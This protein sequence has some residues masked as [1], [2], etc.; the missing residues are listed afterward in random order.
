MPD[1]VTVRN[2]V[3]TDHNAWLPLWRAYQEF[4]EAEIPEETT[5]VTWERILDSREPVF[6]AVAL[7][8]DRV[9]GFVHWLYHRSCWTIGNSAYLQ[10]LFVI[11]DHRGSGVG[12]KLIEHV[13]AAARIG[14]CSKV[15]W[16]THETNKNAMLLYDR[17]AQRSGFIQYEKSIS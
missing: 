14:G 5:R 3:E 13:F 11:P 4:Y 9:V 15:Y 6:G 12:R 7:A 16:L 10:D 2:L 1:S 8:G 17:I